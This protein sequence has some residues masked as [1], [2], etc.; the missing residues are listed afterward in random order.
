MDFDCEK[1]SIS[2][3]EGRPD[4]VLKVNEDFFMIS[5]SANDVYEF[6]PSPL[7]N[8]EDGN[9]LLSFEMTITRLTYLLLW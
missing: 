2:E 7:E 8:V 9:L 3:E 6:I 1:E 5:L 4:G